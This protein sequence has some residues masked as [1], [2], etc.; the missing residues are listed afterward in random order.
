MSIILNIMIRVNNML[1]WLVSKKLVKM[2]VVFNVLT[3]GLLIRTI[4][5]L[6]TLSIRKSVMAN[7]I[8]TLSIKQYQTTLLKILKLLHT[9]IYR[10]II[11]NRIMIKITH[12]H[13]YRLA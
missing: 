8:P 3:M 1:S 6:P 7:F 10:Q 5:K 9:W 13:I 12:I 4:S 11:N 2:E